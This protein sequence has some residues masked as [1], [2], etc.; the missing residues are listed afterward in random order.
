MHISK[1]DVEM[2]GIG[3]SG[4]LS[5]RVQLFA[6]RCEGADYLYRGVRW[7]EEYRLRPQN[8]YL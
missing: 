2:R 7:I 3:V 5:R 6:G 1:L 4:R 8:V